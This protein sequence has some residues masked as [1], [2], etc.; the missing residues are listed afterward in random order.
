MRNTHCMVEPT[1]CQSALSGCEAK[2]GEPT[3]N[4]DGGALALSARRVALSP[5]TGARR[6]GVA[7]RLGRLSSRRLLLRR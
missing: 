3:Q 5:A 7:P 6:R 2:R 1:R 4:S